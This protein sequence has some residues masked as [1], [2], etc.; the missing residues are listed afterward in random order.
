MDLTTPL[1]LFTHLPVKPH[2]ELPEATNHIWQQQF[3]SVYRQEAA[4]SALNLY[5]MQYKRLPQN[6]SNQ[7]YLY[8]TT[9]TNQKTV[10]QILRTVVVII[11]SPVAA[12]R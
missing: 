1:E 10:V 6:K 4:K 8:Q 9:E 3:Q 2:N 12:V 7:I 5:A 11:K